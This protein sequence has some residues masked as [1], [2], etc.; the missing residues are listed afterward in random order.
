V[1]EDADVDRLWLCRFEMAL[2]KAALR[3]DTVDEFGQHRS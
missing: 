1:I 2:N 3:R